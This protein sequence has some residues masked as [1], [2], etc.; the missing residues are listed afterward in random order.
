M[1]E[2]CKDIAGDVVKGFG[3]FTQLYMGLPIN[4]DAQGIAHLPEALPPAGID[5]SIFLNTDKVGCFKKVIGG[6]PALMVGLN[7]QHDKK[8]DVTGVQE[9]INYLMSTEGNAD[10][11]GRIT[12]ADLAKAVKDE[13]L[14]QEQAET[15]GRIITMYDAVL[16]YVTTDEPKVVVAA[17]PAPPPAPVT[18]PVAAGEAPA[19][20]TAAPIDEASKLGIPEKT[21]DGEKGWWA[22]RSSLEKGLIIALGA[23]VTGLG[24]FFAVRGR[25][26]RAERRAEAS[27]RPEG[28]RPA[29]E[30]GGEAP[31]PP[32]GGGAAPG[33]ARAVVQR[34]MVERGRVDGQRPAAGEA[35][36]ADAASAPRLSIQAIVARI[37]KV[38]GQIQA[39]EI[40][41]GQAKAE[42]EAL[43]KG[44]KKVE[45]E[46]R[47][48]Q[49]DKV[50]RLEA[51]KA[52]LEGAKA[53]LLAQKE[54]L[55]KK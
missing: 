11:A 6:N 34:G 23:A 43:P 5:A 44:R 3:S 24:L 2:F 46:A 4:R 53:E 9:I 25:N 29:G 20:L 42:L 39:K 27:R 37:R 28:E 31:P 52:E 51:E 14:T 16:R 18:A 55:K 54:G 19:L 22:S 41:I 7:G 45:I 21:S 10:D 40:E 8:V 35:P 50:S 30:G 13:M 17:P 32:P 12:P 47:K 48:G 26:A 38:D 33:A 1:G 49:A 36:A 15:W